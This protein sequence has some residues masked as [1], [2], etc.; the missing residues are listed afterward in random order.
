MKDK[1][2]PETMTTNTRVETRWV[3]HNKLFWVSRSTKICRRVKVA[4][5]GAGV[6]EGEDLGDA[7]GSG[8][9]EVALEEDSGWQNISTHGSCKIL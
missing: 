5:A 3:A 8:A 2:P 4:A 6:E 7:V 9:A 1:Q